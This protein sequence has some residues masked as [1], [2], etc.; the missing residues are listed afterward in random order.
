M[1]TIYIVTILILLGLNAN[2]QCGGSLFADFSS[3]T[4]CNNSATQFTDLSTTSSGTII[5]WSWDFGDGSP[6][7]GA[8]NPTNSYTN[9]GTYSVTLIVSN[10]LGCA[11]TI[12]QPVQV[13]F[14]PIANFTQNNVCS[15]DTMDFTN[16]SSVDNSTSI[17]SFLWAFGDGNPTDSLQNP[18]HYY[19]NP[20]AYNVTLVTTTI[21]GCSNAFIIPVNVF[22]APTSAFTFSNTCFFDSALFTNTSINPTMG[23]IADWSW[24]FG[25]GSPLNTWAWGASHVYGVSG[26]YQVTL[27]THSSNLGC[28]DTLRD[29]I[30]VFPKPVADFNFNEVCLTDPMNFSDSSLVSNGSIT[31]WQWDFGEGGPISTV[32]NPSYIYYGPGAY[33]V[34]LFVSTN[35]GCKDTVVKSSIVHP[36]PLAQ[37]S[38]PNVCDGSVVQFDDLSSILSTD[39]IQ[40]YL[41]NFGDGSLLSSNQNTSHLFATTG[42]YAVQLLVCSNFGCK[43]SITNYSVV[44]PNP[45]V[46]FT[47]N[48]TVG[49]GPLC[50][51]FQNMSTIATG[52]IS[53]WVWNFGDGSPSSNSQNPNHCFVNDS[54]NSPI[55]FA[56]SLI[57]TSDSGCSAILSKNNYITVDNSPCEAV[58]WPGD[59]DNSTIVDN[60]DILP[61]GLY[62]GQTGIPRASISNIWQADSC[63]NWGIYENNGT[64]MKRADCNGDG[65]IDI[66]DTVAISLN[67]NLTHFIP[68]NN[69][70][71]NE[72]TADDLY[73]VTNGSSFN[74]GNWVDAELWL[75]SSSNPISNMYGI[76]FN[77]NYDAS[78][79]QSGT[80]RITYPSSWLGT[81][82]TNAIKISK[83]D[84]TVNTAYGAVTRIDHADA[85]GYGKIAD[86]KF[87]IKT[88]LTSAVEMPLY[89]SNYLAYDA[90]GISQTFTTSVTEIHT[91]SGITIYPNPF[92]SQ[93]TIAFKEEQK[94]CT[95]RLLDV[96]G[97]EIK[98]INFTGRQLT[99]EK[100]EM[101][102]GIYFVQIIDANKN[103]LNKKIVVQ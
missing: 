56:V 55:S 24:N 68:V 86:F 34:S 48:D 4:V 70:T 28:A 21:D 81:P 79:V 60:N 62:Y 46:N 6:L 87:Q 63:A 100:E 73:F 69:S 89:I 5:T 103:V 50:V 9:G 97:K 99:I 31:G 33:L 74:A 53:E 43:D 38:S 17:S 32:Q 12:T 64:D 61:I 8:I 10:S 36:L 90:T 85:N 51:N 18:I 76:A 27:I 92:T 96:V 1:K 29:S 54:V 75:G 52:I 67:F 13:Y 102:N 35:N 65:I 26:N 98:T 95:I 72:R 83:V 45:V 7:N 41:W 80:E 47:A 16:T 2:A 88:S 14:N 37:Y 91:G 78:L 20:G 44:N 40:S 59:A 66:N 93:T 3:T 15:G 71:N 25:D 101:K 84:A 39:S 42:S 11:D 49:C 57:V 23:T 22:D 77:I 94:N 58:V 19:S 82:G 30:Y